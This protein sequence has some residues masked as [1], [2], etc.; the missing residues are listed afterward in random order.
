[1]G[2]KVGDIV[3]GIG[4]NHYVVT[5]ANLIMK[6]TKSDDEREYINIIVKD[7]SPLSTDKS[8]RDRIGSTYDGLHS[9]AFMLYPPI[10]T[11]EL[12]LGWC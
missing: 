9:S 3:T 6:V 12:L 11:E 1:M 10:T 8:S 2:F 5:N 7:A 4:W